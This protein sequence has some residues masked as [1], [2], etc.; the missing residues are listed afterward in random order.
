VPP[1]E[2][3]RQQTGPLLA[4]RL[5]ERDLRTRVGNERPRSRLALVAL[6]LGTTIL[7]AA[8]GGG[9]S[10]S[11][12]SASSNGGPISKCGLGSGKKATGTPI[13]LGAIVTKQPGTDFTPITGMA[14]AYFNCVNDNGGINGRPVQYVVDQEQT[15]PQQVAADAV[16]LIQNQKVLAMIGGTSLID[17]PVNHAYYEAQGF[18]PIVAGVPKECFFTSNIA[19]VN[20]GPEYSTEGA[21]QFVVSKNPK[22]VVVDG[23]NVPDGQ[24]EIQFAIDYSKSK[25]I[26]TTSHLTNVPITDASGIALR[27]VQ[28]AGQ[29]GAVVLNFTPPEGL[30]ILQAAEQ[31]GLINKVQWAWSTP[32]NDAS[33]AQ[34]LSSAWNGTKLGVNAELNL[35]TANAPDSALYRKVDQQYAPGIPLGSFSQMGFVAADIATKTLLGLSDAQLTQQGVNAALRNVKNF[36]TDIL[37]KP[38]YFGQAPYHVPNNTDRTVSPN[39]HVMTQTQGCFAIAP[40]PTNNLTAVRQAEQQQGLNTA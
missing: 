33:V 16:D 10:T 19:A 8:C 27:D 14:Q 4:V 24:F 9:S 7:V 18:Y 28:E 3:L 32:G 13:K 35:T 21:A 12:S 2:D 5:E 26:H 25:G 11:G 1:A 39:N 22:A 23:A 31:Q 34:A 15:D 30:K 38:W 6:A 29:G 37:C 36:K 20:M 40:L 17:C